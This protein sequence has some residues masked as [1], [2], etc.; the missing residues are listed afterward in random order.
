MVS[1]SIWVLRLVESKER[2]QV[3]LVN[4][5]RRNLGY[6]V[7]REPDRFPDLVVT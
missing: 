7:K 5:T 3:M 6:R 4:E 2:K 1:W